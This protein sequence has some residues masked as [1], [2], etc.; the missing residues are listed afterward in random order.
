MS[1]DD[2]VAAFVATI[3]P[4]NFADELVVI[5][6]GGRVPGI[7]LLRSVL[8]WIESTWS[9]CSAVRIHTARRGMLRELS[10]RGYKAREIVMV[11]ELA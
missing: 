3:D 9:T 7:S 1:G 8:P 5:A 6:A 4:S 11:K 10:K 2:I